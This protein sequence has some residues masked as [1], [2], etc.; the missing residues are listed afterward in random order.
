MEDKIKHIFDAYNLKRPQIE[1]NASEEPIEKKA[2]DILS[3]LNEVINTISVEKIASGISN[4]ENIIL[5]IVKDFN[6]L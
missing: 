2:S 5:S 1:K 4:E 3:K 6:N